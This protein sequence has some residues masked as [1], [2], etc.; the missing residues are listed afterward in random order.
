[1][2]RIRSTNLIT[3]NAGADTDTPQTVM[4]QY[5]AFYLR[6]CLC[7][8]C[9][10]TSSNKTSELTFARQPVYLFKNSIYCTPPCQWYLHTYASHKCWGQW[11][12][13]ITLQMRRSVS[14]FNWCSASSLQNS[15]PFHFW[16]WWIML[17]HSFSKLL[18]HQVSIKV[19][20][21]PPPGG[22]KVTH[23][24]WWFPSLAFRQWDF[25]GVPDCLQFLN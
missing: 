5:L 20:H 25:P 22:L 23:I 19:S 10:L 9:S 13:P 18:I 24:H 21:A 1:M 3:R 4:L 16:M 6:Q 11:C 12:T 2:C 15:F 8:G 7:Y 14:A 17:S